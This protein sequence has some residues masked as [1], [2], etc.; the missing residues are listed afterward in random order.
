MRVRHLL[1]L[2]LCVALSLIAAYGQAIPFSFTGTATQINTD[3]ADP[4][5]GT[6]GLGTT[7]SGSFVFNGAAADALPADPLTG[8]YASSGALYRTILNI[9]GRVSTV[10]AALHIG[11]ANNYPSS[12]DQ[13]AVL[14]SNADGSLVLEFLL[15]DPGGSA[16]N[17]DALPS[18]PP[19]LASFS[20][21]RFTFTAQNI[22]GNYVEILGNI[23]SLALLPPTFVSVTPSAAQPGDQITIT[24]TG[25]VGDVQV[26]FNGVAG[27]VQ[28]VDEN[29]LIVTVPNIPL[30]PVTLTVTTT[31]GTVTA[32]PGALQIGYPTIPT[33]S[34]WGLVL[35]FTAL[36]G[37]GLIRPRNRNGWLS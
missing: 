8:S 25:F 18:T 9:G 10:D 29:T 22:D 30:G 16:F 23:D 27:V 5:A 4:F 14:A 32:P 33:L 35:L 19:L 34:E 13:Y 28:V 12:L 21:A 17:T 6:V 1:G 11:V 31:G 37:I 15:E 20:S 24:G 3:P 36:L 7:F 26:F 2:G